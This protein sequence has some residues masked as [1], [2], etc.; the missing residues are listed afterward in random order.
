MKKSRYFLAVAV[1]V[2]GVA[3]IPSSA[4]AQVSI[5][6]QIGPQPVCPYGYYDYAPYRCAP[7][8][9]YGP[10]WFQNGIF[11][12]T[13]PWFSGPVGFRGYIDRRFDPRFGY[14]GYFP[15]RGERADWDRHRGWE[16]N[17][18]GDE[19]RDERHHD[20]G[21]HYGQYKEHGN[22][23]G[24]HGHGHGHGHERD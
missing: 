5:N 17:W 11:I 16:R 21:N 14:R 22:P 19:W 15:R 7:F 10:A 6:V 4:S 9:Y 2:L 24:E 23:H 8:G 12:G 18:H 3:L 13:G 20:N 1:A